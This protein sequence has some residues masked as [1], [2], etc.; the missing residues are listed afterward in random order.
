[1]SL[2]YACTLFLS[3]ALLMMIQPLCAR[4]LLP[5]LG[6]TPNAWNTCM[7]FF[8]TGLL[9]GY[10]YAHWNARWLMSRWTVVA[11]I[12]LL[13]AGFWF[14]P[15]QL[16]HPAT[17]PDQPVLW[18]LG[19]LGMGIALPYIA[20]AGAGPLLQR[21]FAVGK[22]GN[23]YFLYSASN[24]G[25]FA[26]LLAY[27]LA[28]E[29]WLTLQEQ[30]NLW[31]WGYLGLMALTLACGA[32]LFTRQPVAAPDVPPKKTPPPAPIDWPRRLRWLLLA[33]AP[34]SLLLSVTN[35]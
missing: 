11:Q 26:G 3:A 35:Y 34:S 27:P 1:M 21:W 19:T 15:M 22:F 9:I 7:L 33:L 31:R 4:L 12:V 17:P 20:L 5:T 10:G 13:T 24:V 14:L 16:P 6:G 18:L 30:S 32:A 29:P 23:P 28:M 2:L 8:Q 25:S